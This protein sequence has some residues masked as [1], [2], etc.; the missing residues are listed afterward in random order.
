MCW[1]VWLLSYNSLGLCAAPAPTE[2]DL[3][4]LQGKW[5]LVGGEE[6]GRES[7]RE[8]DE[9]EEVVVVIEKGSFIVW[10]HKEVEEEFSLTIKPSAKPKEMDLCFTKGD[11][12]GK[13]CL[14]IYSLDGDKLTLCTNTKLRATDG[15]KR[16]TIFST[17]KP[18]KE[19]DVP[20]VLLL[21]L[22]RQK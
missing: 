20:G 12:K 21:I 7:T 19:S 2:T 10:K 9:K 16:P 18:T 13:F 5:R 3:S 11:D 17:K 15:Q 1:L 4:A 14:A 8:E 6:V 22:E